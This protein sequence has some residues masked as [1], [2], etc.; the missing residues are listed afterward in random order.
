MFME[1]R[2]G[3]MKIRII[4]F[5]CSNNQAE[6]EIMV[7]LLVKAGFDIVNDITSADLVVVNSCFVK[8]PTQNR[9][10]K[11]IK[12][13]N[14]EFPEKKLIIAG[15]MPEGDYK[16][17]VSTA[18]KAS[19]VSTHHITR[20]V[21]AVN[22]TLNGKRIEFLGI[23]KENRL[24]QPR[25]RKN[26]VINIVPIS[27]GCNSMCA[28]CCVRFAKGKL[29]SHEINDIVKEIKQGLKQG[30][31]EVWITSQ[32]NS[33]YGFDINTNLAKLLKEI[34]EIPGKFFIRI[35]M[36]NPNNILKFLPDL[37]EIYKNPKIF[38]FLH[39]PVQSGNDTI[40]KKMDRRYR[41]NNFKNI[42][43][44]FRKSIPKITISTDI[45]VGFP[46]E[47]EEQF[48]DSIELIKW[49]KPDV[50]N[51]SR[52]WP[53]PGTKAEEMENQIHG[54]ITK[55]GS[56]VLTRLFEKISLEKNMEWNNWQGEILIDKKVKNGYVGRN[57]YY[58][59]IFVKKAKPGEFKRIKIKK[60]YKHHLEAV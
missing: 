39:I 59:P 25:I 35:G 40:L 38:K 5:G 49:L 54:R 16:T 3:C 2:L 26:Q 27:S 45:I 46:G 12:K 18:P 41:V 6:S 19:L 15:C 58:K 53:R 37:I 33:C 22:E 20:I 17:T 31:K 56:R 34:V 48:N 4:T 36:M 60:T 51:I 10:I 29:F 30:C 42:I 24:G 7:G 55:Q 43:K 21:E 1:N 57:I 32:D 28:Y 14:N 8:M 52:F 47:T 13:I 23:K 50:L 44:E 11:L 9:V